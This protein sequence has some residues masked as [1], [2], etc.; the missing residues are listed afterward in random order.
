LGAKILTY[1][2]APTSLDLDTYTLTHPAATPEGYACTHPTYSPVMS[3][4][5]SKSDNMQHVPGCS[6]VG[7]L[8]MPYHVSKQRLQLDMYPG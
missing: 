6:L 4:K 5:A 3:G 1:K 2:P 7:R 8:L